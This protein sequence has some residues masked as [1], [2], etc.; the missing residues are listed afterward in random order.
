MVCIVS[1]NQTL[2]I[3]LHIVDAQDHLQGLKWLLQLIAQ[4]AKSSQ[5]ENRKLKRKNLKICTLPCGH[6][7]EFAHIVH[8]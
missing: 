3:L 8:H 1:E 2:F 4:Y 7:L 5:H 6:I